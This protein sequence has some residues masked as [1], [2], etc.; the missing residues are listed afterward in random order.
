MSNPNTSAMI[1]IHT[2]TKAGWTTGELE[3]K[4]EYGTLM[5]FTEA[6]SERLKALQTCF[7]ELGGDSL[8]TSEVQHLVG[9]CLYGHA[10]DGYW[11][12]PPNNPS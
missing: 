4:K 10:E 9:I 3:F 8:T 12:L 2:L 6:G 1:L 11:V 7:R 5:E